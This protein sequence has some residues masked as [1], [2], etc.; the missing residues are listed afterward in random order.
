[1]WFHKIRNRLFN[2]RV[3]F[4]NTIYYNIAYGNPRASKEQIEAAARKAQ[5]HDLIS[6]WPKGYSTTVGERGL[7]LS[8]GEKQ[9]VAIARLFLKDPQILLFDEPTSSLDSKTEQL[10][11]EQFNE[12]SKNK[13]SIMI[14][15][16]LSTIKDADQYML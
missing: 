12:I 2:N 14:A 15:H 3:L 8:G 11:M 16:R 9:R 4:N 1:M 10:I 6:K 13:T 7:M 5:L